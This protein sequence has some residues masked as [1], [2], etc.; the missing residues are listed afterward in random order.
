[1]DNLLEQLQSAGPED[2]AKVLE[3]L[4]EQKGYS[5]GLKPAGGGR[6]TPQY[7]ACVAAHNGQCG[8]CDDTGAFT[9]CS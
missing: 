8:S 9:P 4:G 5:I 1:M 3:F 6:H 2:M 7:Y